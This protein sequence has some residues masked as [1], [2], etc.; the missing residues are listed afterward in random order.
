MEMALPPNAACRAET[1]V[2]R[3]LYTVVPVC[4]LEQRVEKSNGNKKYF[5]KGKWG[6]AYAKINLFHSYQ[7]F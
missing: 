5:F 6:Y 7:N 1:G 3:K 2:F 4:A